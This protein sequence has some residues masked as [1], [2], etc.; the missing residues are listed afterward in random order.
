MSKLLFCADEHVLL[1]RKKVPAEFELNRYKLLFSKLLELSNDHDIVIHGGDMFDRQPTISEVA[2][3][4]DYL[5]NQIR[6]TYII[7]GNHEATKKGESFLSELSVLVSNPLVHIITEV[8]T[9]DV[10]GATIGFVPYTCLK[11]FTGKEIAADI[12]ITHVRGEIPPHVKPEVDLSV[13]SKFSLVLAGD[14]HSHSNSQ[15][16]IVYPGSP[17]TT[18]FYRNKPTKG[19]LSVDCSTREYKFIDLKLPALLRVTTDIAGEKVVNG[20]YIDYELISKDVEIIQEHSEEAGQFTKHTSRVDALALLI[21][22]EYREE[23][24]DLYV[25]ITSSRG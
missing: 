6:P 19:V 3:V 25:K 2:L 12:L 11:T 1:R 18:S 15:L 14:L 5:N 21:P 23:A 17:L 10:T 9:V 7:D 13:F 22:N 20:D 8:G 16:N 24:I 4:V